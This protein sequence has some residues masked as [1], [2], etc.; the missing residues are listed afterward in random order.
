MRT[1]LQRSPPDCPEISFLRGRDEQSVLQALSLSAW[2]PP[3]HVSGTIESCCSS[4]ACYLECTIRVFRKR[5][6]E[7]GGVDTQANRL[8]PISVSVFC[9][10]MTSKFP[11]V[12]EGQHSYSLSDSLIRLLCKIN[13]P[14]SYK[15]PRSEE[16]TS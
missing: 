16:H 1:C 4:V 3:I 7:W 13:Y 2:T 15:C 9:C 14:P 10:G 12:R 8:G 5:I 11:R 6:G